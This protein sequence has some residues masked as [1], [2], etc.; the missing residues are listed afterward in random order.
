MCDFTITNW[1]IVRF[2][3]I[4]P[5]KVIVVEVTYIERDTAYTGVTLH[6][7]LVHVQLFIDW[8]CIKE[9]PGRWL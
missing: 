4:L 1:Q 2:I 3:S 7:I 8:A 9:N 6:R 5:E